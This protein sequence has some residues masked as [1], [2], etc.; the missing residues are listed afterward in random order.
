MTRFVR[1]LAVKFG[2]S[3][4]ENIRHHYVF[5]CHGFRFLKS[6][7]F[8]AEKCV[9]RFG[10]ARFSGIQWNLDASEVTAKTKH[11]PTP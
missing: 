10:F 9:Q 2:C 6:D 3:G 5:C 1:I 4:D 7:C 11:A 8:G